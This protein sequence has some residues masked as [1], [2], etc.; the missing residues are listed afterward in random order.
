MVSGS[1]SRQSSE[2]S[3]TLGRGDVIVRMYESLMYQ[4]EV[5]ALVRLLSWGREPES[6]IR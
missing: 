4:P 2:A 1:M 6:T 5:I 3:A